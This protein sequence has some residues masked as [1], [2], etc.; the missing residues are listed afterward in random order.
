MPLL[1]TLVAPRTV[2]LGDIFFFHDAFRPLCA[3]AIA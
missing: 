1:L 3:A 2:R